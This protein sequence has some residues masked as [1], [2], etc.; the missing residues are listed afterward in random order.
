MVL[1]NEQKNNLENYFKEK[2]INGKIHNYINL[3]TKIEFIQDLSIDIIEKI[4]EILN[5]NKKFVLIRSFQNKIFLIL[6]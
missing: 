6:K 3:N 2:N 1:S 5:I 4:I